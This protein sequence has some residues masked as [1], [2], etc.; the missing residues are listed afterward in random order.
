[1]NGDVLP[2][3]MALAALVVPIALV[4]LMIEWSARMQRKSAANHHPHA[5]PAAAQR[6][7]PPP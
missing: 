6:Q 7:A 1:M 2:M 3:L 4:Y 5:V